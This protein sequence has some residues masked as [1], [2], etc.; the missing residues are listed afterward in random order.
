M[1]C[2]RSAVTTRLV[3]I[4]AAG[5]GGGV[6]KKQSRFGAT[7]ASWAKSGSIFA[8]AVAKQANAEDTR[9]S[10]RFTTNLPMVLLLLE[11]RA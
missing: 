5:V 4:L 7:S 2:A 9:N 8:A 10:R 6:P 3:W 11:A 1:R